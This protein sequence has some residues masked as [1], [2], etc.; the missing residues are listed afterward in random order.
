M[1]DTSAKLQLLLGCQLH[2]LRAAAECA[3]VSDELR[4]AADHAP[5]RQQLLAVAVNILQWGGSRYT[6]RM[7]LVPAQQQL[8]AVTVNSLQ[9]GALSV[10]TQSSSQT[11]H[12]L[13]HYTAK[14]CIGICLRERIVVKLSGNV[15]RVP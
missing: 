11:A 5:A 12:C 10:C 4:A 8:L 7:V 6:L 3:R 9:W 2:Q 13:L 15:L 14:C 1:L